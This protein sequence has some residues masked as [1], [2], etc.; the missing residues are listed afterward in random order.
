MSVGI[1]D[2]DAIFERIVDARQSDGRVGVMVTVI[3][4]GLREVDICD[5][6]GGDDKKGILQECAC[7]SHGSRSSEILLADD[8]LDVHAEGTAIAEIAADG[9]RLMIENDNEVVE[10]VFLQK[11]YDVLHHGSVGK[12]YHRLGGV[13]GQRPQPRTKSTGKNDCFH[14][15]AADIDW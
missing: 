14:W 7:Q 12:R 3:L 13:D 6:I 5:D 4:D 8:V 10:S 2:D 1:G 9:I 15:F 11:P